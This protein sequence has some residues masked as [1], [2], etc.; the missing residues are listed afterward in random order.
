MAIA[1][2]RP[3]GERMP[4]GPPSAPPVE[5][6]ARAAAI[7]GRKN[8]Q[9]DQT[10]DSAVRTTSRSL[11]QGNDQR[12]PEQ[13]HLSGLAKSGRGTPRRSQPKVSANKRPQGRWLVAIVGEHCHVS[14]SS[15][16]SPI[17]EGIG[18][19][20]RLAAVSTLTSLPLLMEPR[21]APGK[22]T[23][24]V[25]ICHKDAPIHF[26]GIARWLAHWATLAGI[27]EIRE[28]GRVAPRIAGMA[29]C[30]HAPPLDVLVTCVLRDA[31]G[32]SGSQLARRAARSL[33]SYLAH[34]SIPA[35]PAY[36]SGRPNTKE[37]RLLSGVTSWTG[38]IASGKNILDERIFAHRALRYDRFHPGICPDTGMRRVFPGIG[39]DESAS[40]ADGP[41]VD[42]GNRFL[43]FRA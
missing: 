34:Q 17:R 39:N 12:R 42:T 43:P 37:S 32:E 23:R 31:R 16:S 27:V 26:D 2:T 18:G 41:Q 3:P 5:R 19:R 1:A 36:S 38:F 4:E 25:L 10:V 40:W 29:T 24:V 14:V 7:R 11:P 33:R 30:G 21:L 35:R 28:R 8:R 22:P 15:L 9:S 20:R 13:P 6:S